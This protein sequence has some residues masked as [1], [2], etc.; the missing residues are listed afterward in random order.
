MHLCGIITEGNMQTIT[1][2][3]DAGHQNFYHESLSAWACYIRTPMRT[4][5]YSGTIKRYVKGS[6]QAEMYAIAN[7]L[8]LLAKE[9]DLS[10]Y[11]VILYSDNTYAIRNHKN[12]TIRK[13]ASSEWLDVYNR[14]I[15]P[16]VETAFDYDARHVKAHLPKKRWSIESAR[17]YM[18]DWCDREV[19]KIMKVARK[20]ILKSQKNACASKKKG[21]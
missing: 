12:G 11:R 8:W 4:I 17:H 16:H 18:Q 14:Y 20:E 9:Y 21:A 15:R 10:K 3:T 7:A 5:H 13:N 2:C 19:H 1:I 6:S